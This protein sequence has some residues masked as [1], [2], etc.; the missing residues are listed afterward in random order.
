MKEGP[1]EKVL[2]RKGRILT[3]TSQEAVECGLAAGRIADIVRPW[4]GTGIL[5]VE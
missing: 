3:L 4:S 1:G 5:E 2:C